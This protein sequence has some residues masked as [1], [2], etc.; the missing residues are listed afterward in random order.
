MQAKQPTSQWVP[1]I[2]VEKNRPDE[3]VLDEVYL[4]FAESDPFLPIIHFVD[5]ATMGPEALVGLG[6][7]GKV[8]KWISRHRV[9]PYK[10][11]STGNF[12]P[13]AWTTFLGRA[14]AH[15]DWLNYFE[16][17]LE[18]QPF[19]DVLARWAPRFA[20][21]VGAFLFHG[22]IRTAHAVRALDHK[23]TP[24]RRGELARGLALWAIGIKTDPPDPVNEPPRDLNV[25][26]ELLGYAK[27]GAVALIQRPNVPRVHLVTGPM[28]YHMI[29]HHL[30]P[31]DHGTALASFANTH[32]R[33]VGDFEIKKPGTLSHPIPSFDDQ[34][35]DALVAQSDAHPIKLTEAAL[36]AFDRTKDELFLKA[37]GKAHSLHSLRSL[38][39]IV[40]ALV[41]RRVA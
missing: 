3:D 5:H 26:T 33:V 14:D 32:A 24:A 2:L 29:L 9:R 10:R 25:A 38:L 36:R 13:S 7:G 18:T 11:Q 4:L 35:L 21:E 27:A 31:A 12:R 37:A 8:E 16:K 1:D 28:A 19:R 22:L 41:S 6:L 20:H 34:E 40:K 30:E 39:G 17:E 23:D 15:G